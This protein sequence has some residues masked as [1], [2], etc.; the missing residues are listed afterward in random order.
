MW[1]LDKA[2]AAVETRELSE[3]AYNVLCVAAKHAHEGT[4]E[5]AQSTQQQAET[6]L[7]MHLAL[8]DGLRHHIE[9]L[10]TTNRALERGLEAKT[11]QCKLLLE[12]NEALTSCVDSLQKANRALH[13]LAHENAGKRKRGV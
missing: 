9:S 2:E 5:T 3:G 1:L 13:E 10:N 8:E 4:V 6:L 12:E 7:H 11:M